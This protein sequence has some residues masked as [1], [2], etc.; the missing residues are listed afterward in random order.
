MFSR[1]S[2][3]A[4]PSGP[5]WLIVGRVAKPHG[6]HGDI[7]V[8]IVTDFPQ[9]LIDGI[10]FGVGDGDAPSEFHRAHRVRT[11]GGRWLISVGGI[12]ARGDVEEWR[13]RWLF[14]PEQ[15][16]EELPEGYYYEHQLLDLRC[17]SV[18]GDDLGQVVGVDP[19]S[20]Q[21][22]LV[23]R[24]DRRDYLVPYVPAIVLEVDLNAG[25]VILDPPAGLFDDDFAVA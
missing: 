5:A 12:R 23:I 13:G 11:H 21:G 4:Q 17:R 15:P 22:R 18:G 7:L 9:R 1:S 19:G 2:N 24:K 3:D 8:D 25:I 14:L 16:L 20:H 6:V 10:D